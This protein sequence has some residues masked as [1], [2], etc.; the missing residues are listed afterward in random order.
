VSIKTTKAIVCDKCGAYWTIGPD[1]VGTEKENAAMKEARWECSFKRYS[2]GGH[3]ID[4]CWGCQRNR[5]RE[6]AHV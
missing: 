1:V 2:G 4:L 3:W 5:E 6:A